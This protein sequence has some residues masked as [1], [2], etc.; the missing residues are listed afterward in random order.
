MAKFHFKGLMCP[1]FT[2][3]DK[4]KQVDY[5]VIDK[6]CCYLKTKGVNG[7][8]VNG[9]TGEGTCLRLDE[10]KRLAEEWLVACRKYG[11]TMMIQIGGCDVLS[12]F[13]LAQHAE[14]I[15]VDCVLTLPDL[16]FKPKIEEDLVKYIKSIAQHCPTRPL[17]YYHIP[18]MS[19]VDLNMPR[20]YDLI[21]KEV[22]TFHGLKYTNGNME[23]G[24]QLIKEGRN[25]MLGADTILW[26]ALHL[27]FD[28]AILTT[29][30]IC[31][32]TIREIYEHYLNNNQKEGLQV[33]RKLNQYIIDILSKDTGEWVEN[34]KNEFNRVNASLKVGPVRKPTIMCRRL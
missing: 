6:Y 29:L 21:E 13:E 11:V 9:T 19:G 33:Q 12:V 32:D 30:N 5:A 31:P 22:P 34:M 18:S 7:V 15:G 14:K 4:D 1:T 10:R 23:L 24:I 26:G 8:L 16:F 3:F 2:A 20:F 17:Y 28:A 27:G 25:I